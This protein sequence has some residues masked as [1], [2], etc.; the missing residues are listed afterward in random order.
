MAIERVQSRSDRRLRTE[1]KILAAAGD[2]FLDLGYRKT[3]VRG[4]AER[5]EV[6]TGRV[7]AAGDKDVLLV[8]CFDRW[9]AGLQSGQYSPPPRATA[10]AA[11]DERGSGRTRMPPG[12]TS[13]VQ[14]HLLEIF[15]PFL[16]FF[17]A[18]EGLSRDYAAALMRV[19]GRPRVFDALATD[20]QDKLASNLISIGLNESYARASAAVLYDSYLGIIFRWAASDQTFDEAVAS[21]SQ[22]ITFHTQ[23]R[24]LG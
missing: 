18:H 2:L 7:M 22:I 14:Q 4:I 11:D 1:E 5:A 9:I 17:A 10:G 12:I 19:Q 21:L 8:R 3:T 24:R 6:S 13:A 15:L 20:L 16:E 23:F